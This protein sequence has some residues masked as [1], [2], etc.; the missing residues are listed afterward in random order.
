MRTA[1]RNSRLPMS[2]ANMV[3]MEDKIKALRKE[4]LY[5][6][7]RIGYEEEHTDSIEEIETA[8]KLLWKEY[9]N[10]KGPVFESLNTGENY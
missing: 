5:E 7:A 4:R 9:H 1:G 6:I 2:E 10:C 3:Q 8:R